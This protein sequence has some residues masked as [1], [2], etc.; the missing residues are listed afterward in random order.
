[1]RSPELHVSN[2]RGAGACPFDGGECDSFSPRGYNLTRQLRGYTNFFQDTDP[3]AANYDLSRRRKA[4]LSRTIEE[5]PAAGATRTR[6]FTVNEWTGTVTESG[7][8]LADTSDTAWSAVEVS[9]SATEL[10]LDFTFAP[11]A[12]L[13]FRQTITL[14]DEV[15]LEDAY[16]ELLSAWLALDKTGVASGRTQA[17]K[18]DATGAVVTDGA[19]TVGVSSAHFGPFSDVQ[20]TPDAGAVA[21][22]LTRS[23][24][25]IS[26]VAYADFFTPFRLRYSW[27]SVEV[28]PSIGL[29][30]TGDGVERFG[31]TDCG[32]DPGDGFVE[33][34]DGLWLLEPRSARDQFPGWFAGTS[35]SAASD[36]F[37]RRMATMNQAPPIVI[38]PRGATVSAGGLVTLSGVWLNLLTSVAWSNGTLFPV[39]LGDWSVTGNSLQVR[40]RSGGVSLAPGNYWLVLSYA[41]GVGGGTYSTADNWPA[42]FTVGVV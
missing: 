3:L 15:T 14:A 42:P 21:G 26:A 18:F 22:D 36:L 28:P 33:I 12:L 19:S 39:A 7:S 11:N 13:N 29:V 5:V 9:R 35:L 32:T 25:F 40:A 31:Q 38:E 37:V 2:I 34:E 8:A 1:M 30:T 27:Q 24:A 41:E 10:V 16:D 17:W 6:T 20:L 23:V 4:Y